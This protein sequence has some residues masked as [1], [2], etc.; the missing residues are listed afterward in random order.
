MCQKEK[1]EKYVKKNIRYFILVK[2]KENVYVDWEKCTCR[3]H[4]TNNGLPNTNVLY[5]L[6]FY[7]I[8][9]V[10]Y[11]YPLYNFTLYL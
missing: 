7:I 9:L 3:P 10:T 6:A 2:R 11:G 5:K 4:P 1:R 8:P